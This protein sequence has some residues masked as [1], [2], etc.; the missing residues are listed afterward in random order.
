MSIEEKE[1]DYFTKGWAESLRTVEALPIKRNGKVVRVLKE[2][3]SPQQ[4]EEDITSQEEI[5]E[6]NELQEDDLEDGESE[7][8][9]EKK[10]GKTP[11]VMAL[12]T[13]SEKEINKFKMVVAEICTSV[14][15][16]PENSFQHH[17][18]RDENTKP[19]M[20]D[21]FHLLDTG[22]VVEFEIAM[23]STVLVFKDICPSYRIRTTEEEPSDVQQKKE[24]RRLKKFESSLLESYNRFLKILDTKIQN[25]LKSPLKTIKKWD[26]N[27]KLGLNA[28]KCTCELLLALYH[29]NFRS[30]LLVTVIDRAMQ[31]ENQVSQVCCNTIIKLF[32][33]D[34]NGEIS[35]EMMKTIAKGLT[36]HKYNVF[37]IVIRTLEHI[38][39]TVHADDSK[40][41]YKKAKTERKKRKRAKDEASIEMLESQAVSDATAAKRFQAE[42]LQELCL[43]YF[44]ILKLKIGFSLLPAALEGLGRITHL[45]NIDTVEDL[46]I[47][48]YSLL[49]GSSEGAGST[50]EL[51]LLTQLHSVHCA[52]KTLSGPG[53]E[54]KTDPDVYMLKFRDILRDIPLHSGFNGNVDGKDINLIEGFNRWDLIV[55]CVDLLFVKKREERNHI[56]TT[57]IRQLLLIVLH[58]TAFDTFS[59][60][61]PV[62]LLLSTV[63]KVLQRYPRARQNLRALSLADSKNNS[64]GSLTT[65][66]EDEDRVEDLAMEALKEESGKS[67]SRGVSAVDKNE[68]LLGDG[69]WVLPM[70]NLHIN[71]HSKAFMEGNYEAMN[72]SITSRDLRPF[73]HSLIPTIHVLPVPNKVSGKKRKGDKFNGIK[74]GTFLQKGLSSELRDRVVRNEEEFQLDWFQM[75]DKCLDSLPKELVLEKPNGWDGK[76]KVKTK[77]GFLKK[78]QKTKV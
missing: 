54:L 55:D 22:D 47:N 50:P 51:P 33:S 41:I 53:Q 15:A 32:Q 56:I 46:M 1:R 42:S 31:R 49:I 70:L 30:R 10:I 3:A 36:I 52:L 76:T 37:D 48:L 39:V 26:L 35:C 45:I 21:L 11:K 64:L 25:G 63:H 65:R 29:F 18:H 14:T 44:R 66:E 43:I 24:T 19:Q 73:P 13:K 17:S 27:E 67:K 61:S 12:S 7:V 58:F 78:K 28:L 20:S 5:L 16:D 68:E 69:S 72:E 34:L 60:A 75:L 71:N 6:E 4:A 8:Q 9:E 59:S 57:F 77:R 23:F 40:Q 62:R 74:D 2:Q 38:K